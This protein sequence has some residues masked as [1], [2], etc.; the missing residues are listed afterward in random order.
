MKIFYL[1][2]RKICFIMRKITLILLC[3]SCC[4]LQVMA[5]SR[6]RRAVPTHERVYEEKA[7][8][9]LKSFAAYLDSI[10]P[11]SAMMPSVADDKQVS[12]YLYKVT[13]P[14]VYYSSAIR[15]RFNLDW[16]VG[17]TQQPAQES[18]GMEYR[19]HLESVI[20]QALISNYM[21][22]P[23][24]VKYYDQQIARETIVSNAKVAKSETKDLDKILRN[25]GDMT[26][27]ADVLGSMDIGLKFERPNFWKTS[28]EFDLQF[29]QNYFSQNWYKGGNNNVTLL[30]TLILQANYND[31]QRIQW[32]NKLEMRLGFVS[33]PSDTVHSF[34]T[35]NDKIYLTSKLGVKAVEKLFYTL[36]AEAQTQFL[37]GYKSNDTT[38]YSR[39]FAPIDVFVSLGMDYKPSFKNGSSLSLAFLPLSYK[40]R[41]IGGGDEVIIKAYKMR[42]GLRCQNDFGSKIEVNA[43]VKILKNFSWRSRFY[44]YTNYKYVEAE[45]ENKFSFHF[46][47]YISTELYTLWRFDDN[48]DMKYWDD[49]LGF[50]QFKEFFSLG[51]A[52]KF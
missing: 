20:D 52:Y 8:S 18:G 44:Y 21:N 6:A 51:L 23:A 3:L 10:R 35:N 31:Q 5:Q 49:T 11:D 33:V 9:L 38:A 43:D 27:V 48:R 41:Y 50:F 1:N 34:L 45:F 24:T 7:D 4:I 15:N 17:D 36:Q 28:G 26:D 42:D 32:D 19:E 25:V 22:R 12:P 14:A 40:M 16:K 46:N 2:L 47:Q 13:G 37:P 29:T 39:F 30:S